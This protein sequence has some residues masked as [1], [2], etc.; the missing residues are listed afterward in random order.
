[1]K[2]AS[3]LTSAFTASQ[4]EFEWH[5]RCSKESAVVCTVTVSMSFRPRVFSASPPLALLDRRPR[6]GLSERD[7]PC[8]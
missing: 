2:A 7:G 1:M 3:K 4:A 6:L 5:K 8:M